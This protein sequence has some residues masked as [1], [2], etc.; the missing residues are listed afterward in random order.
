MAK[1][2]RASV[3]F[4]RESLQFSGLQGNVLN[5]LKETYPTIDVDTELKKMGLWLTSQKGLKRKG[6]M[7]FIINWLNNAT[8]SKAALHSEIEEKDTPI[9]PYL[10]E[11][12]ED[13]WQKNNAH[14][15]L[16]LN[17]TKRKI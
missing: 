17:K 14:L 3:Y 9:R 12:I 1:N 16:A 2:K 15:V 7:G 5:Q 10:N 8:P 11:Y 4:D 6:D 13:M